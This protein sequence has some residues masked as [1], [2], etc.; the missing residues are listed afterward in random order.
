M[1]N[2]L[3]DYF[4]L[5]K[6][7]NKSINKAKSIHG[8]KYDYSRVHEDYKTCISK[9][10]IGCPEHGFFEQIFRKHYDGQKCPN[11]NI[12]TASIEIKIN[13]VINKSKLTHGNKY[14]YSRVH[15]T[16]KKYNSKVWIGC[17]EHGFFQQVIQDHY[18]GSGCL[19][20]STRHSPTDVRIKKAIIQAKEVHGD[21]YDYSRIHEDFKNVNSKVW[22]GCQEHGFFKQQLHG[23]IRGRGCSRC[24][25]YAITRPDRFKLAID[26]A[27]KTHGGKYDY[28]RVH[29]DYKNSGSKVLVGCREHGWFVVGIGDHYMGANCPDCSPTK[30][31]VK[32]R[33]KNVIRESKLIHGNRYDYSRLHED[34]KNMN[35]VVIIGCGKHGWFQQKIINHIKGTGCE[36]CNLDINIQNAI[37]KAISIHGTRYKYDRVHEDY[38][39]KTTKVWIGCVEHGYFRQSMNA[40]CSG[41][42]CPECNYS[43]MERET[44]KQLNKQGVLFEPQKTFD[45]LIGVGRGLLS[46]DFYLPDHNV[47]IEC[48]GVQHHKY[49][50]SFVGDISKFHK[51]QKHDKR[52]NEYCRDNGIRLIRLTAKDF[53]KI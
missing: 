53:N 21:R 25:K 13:D 38:K 40:H 5:F 20:C 39:Y 2:K 31:S 52:K 23:H 22:I 12:K 1:S 47:A 10:L 43:H 8:D 6:R 3:Q 37:D 44:A 27:Q 28:S 24:D 30:A 42:G 45:G 35:S 15:E 29:E 17:P 41:H 51:Q 14:N 46:F 4:N 26:R 32:I 50:P 11:C 48:D 7:L 49:V 16:F 18:M 33:I 19:S 36:K 9:V 34:Y